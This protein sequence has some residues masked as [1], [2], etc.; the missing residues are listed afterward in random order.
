MDY[1]GKMTVFMAVILLLR[2]KAQI[3]NS[4]LK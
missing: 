1:I 2:Q 4:T 3:I